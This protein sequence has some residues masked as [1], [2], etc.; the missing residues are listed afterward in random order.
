MSK[1]WGW[2]IVAVWI[3][4]LIGE[5]I[6]LSWWPAIMVVPVLLTLAGLLHFADDGLWRPPGFAALVGW[7]VLLLMQCIPLPPV[8]LSLL[9][10]GSYHL[11]SETVWVLRPDAWMP[12][13]LTAKPAFLCLMQYMAIA[14]VFF[15]TVQ[16]GADHVGLGKLLHWFALVAGLVALAMIVGRLNSLGNVFSNS[17][18]RGGLTSLASLVPVV[19]A[20]HLYAKPHQNYGKWTTRLVQALRHPTHHLHGYLFGATLLMCIAVISFGS[21]QIQV[22]LALGLLLMTGL[23]FLRRSSRAGFMAV[24]LISLLVLV[25]VGL[26]SRKTEHRGLEN[27]P[28]SAITS[29]DRQS[30]IKDFVLFGAGPGNFSSM[31]M[32]YTT[33]AASPDKKQGLE[34]GLPVLFGGGLVGVFF[35]LCFWITVLI[36]GI[37]G[38]L[39]R[40]NRMS[41]YLFPGVLAGLVVCFASGSDPLQPSVLWPGMTGY[42][43]GALLIAIGCF[44]S[45]GEPDSILGDL[46]PPARWT[47]LIIVAVFGLG[48]ALYVGGK[49]WL[50]VSEH[51]QPAESIQATSE[52]ARYVL[53]DLQKK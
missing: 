16:T 13:A 30:M 35:V 24:V 52:D 43:L 38:W 19:L 42:F 6:P 51:F 7:F 1:A 27:P 50:A 48:G 32:R 9:S 2:L 8:I 34:I 21:P 23:L 31:E 47:M 20:C 3:L 26:G 29:L 17:L 25:V 18:Y 44:S 41:L 15:M 39:R 46:S 28:V 10:P 22:S 49:T 14:G 12:L 45:S 33:L 36:A 37:T 5:V 4:A 11:Y 40:R 53:G